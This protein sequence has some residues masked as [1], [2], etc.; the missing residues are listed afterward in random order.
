MIDE[1][2]GEVEDANREL[3]SLVHFDHFNLH[4]AAQEINAL[5]M[6]HDGLIKEVERHSCSGPRIGSTPL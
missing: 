1:E 2:H 3:G 6:Q 4:Q 5:S